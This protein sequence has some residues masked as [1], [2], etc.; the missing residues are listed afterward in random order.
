MAELMLTFEVAKRLGVSSNRVRQLVVEGKLP[1]TITETG[2]RVYHRTDVEA[3]GGLAGT[4]GRGPEGSPG[5]LSRGA[6]HPP[7]VAVV[8]ATTRDS[9][10]AAVKG[11]FRTQV[12]RL[13]LYPSR[14]PA[15]LP[16]PLKR[17]R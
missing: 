15:S 16:T 2:R 10:G 14:E 1:A 4:T 6:L 13:S 11:R 7:A 8:M 12:E 17:F 9:P 5:R 3:P